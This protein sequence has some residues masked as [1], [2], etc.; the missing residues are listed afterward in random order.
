MG[1]EKWDEL[2]RLEQGSMSIME[3]AAKCNELG[4]FDPDV[5]KRSREKG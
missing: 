2:R 3:Y 5:I 1:K 4:H